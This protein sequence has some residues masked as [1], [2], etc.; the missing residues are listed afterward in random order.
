MS[1]RIAIYGGTF[2]PIHFGHLRSIDELKQRLEFN[3]V[4]LIP[5]YIP[6][7]RAEPGASSEDRL[8]M[9]RLAAEEFDE[10]VVDEREIQRRGTSYTVDTLAEIRGDLRDDA[11]LMFVLGTDAYALL[12]EWYRWEKLTDYAH[13]IVMERPGLSA[14]V[15]DG[16]VVEWTK[17]RLLDSVQQLEGPSGSVVKI[18]LSPYEISATEIRRRVRNGVD[19]TQWLPNA[20]ANYIKAHKLYT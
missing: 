2:D 9:L 3:T 12:H 7:H 1:Q 5:S 20:V 10:L 6:P 8:N 4:R 19:C 18:A 14:E 13:L 16:Q 17:A 15:V 11:Q